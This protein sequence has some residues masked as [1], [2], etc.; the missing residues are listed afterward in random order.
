MNTRTS[1]ICRFFFLFILLMCSVPTSAKEPELY[2]ITFLN[3]KRIKIGDYTLHCGDVF[4]DNQTIFWTDARQMMRVVKA[5]VKNSPEVTITK[6]GFRKYES[7]GVKSLIDYLMQEHFLG[8]RDVGR[9]MLHYSEYDHYLADTLLFP[10]RNANPALRVEAVWL[11]KGKEVVTPVKM[12]EDKQF[13]IISVDVYGKKKPRDI[14]L[15]IR[16]V[17]D[18]LEW[19]NQEYRDIPIIYIP[20]EL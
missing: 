16:V 1:K 15:G 8:T 7:K 11:H 10:V 5:N 4:S 18:E 14:K 19:I 13:Y 12:T 17:N 9:Q 20:C 3:T 2:K 6:H